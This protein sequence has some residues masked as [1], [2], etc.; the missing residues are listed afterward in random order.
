MTFTHTTL[1]LDGPVALVT[2]N[3]PQ[4]RN[5]MNDRLISELTR[6]ASELEANKKVR[7]VVLTGAGSSFCAGM[8]LDYL[9]KLADFD[10]AQNRQDTENLKALFVAI[11]RSRLPWVAAVNGPAIAGGCGLATLCDLIV[12]DRE[13][14]RFGYTETRIGFI[15]ALVTWPLVQRVGETA[16]RDLLLGGRIIKA[17]YAQS[18]GLINELSEP[19]QVV[20]LA[21]SPAR[22]LATQ[23]SGSSLA[24]TKALIEEVQGRSFEDSLEISLE[25]NVKLRMS[26][27]CKAGVSAFLHKEKLDWSTID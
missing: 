19:G 10:E 23:S 5:A 8:D 20:A 6:I 14:A 16:A 1:H 2:L 21:G 27:S 26:K 9:R 25:A 11:R 13:T 12:A 7:A 4:I 22:A 3:R 15:P 17:D 24:A 18:I